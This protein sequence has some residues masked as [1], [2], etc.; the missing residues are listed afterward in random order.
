MTRLRAASLYLAPILYG[1]RVWGRALGIIR[2]PAKYEP[3]K[4]G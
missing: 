2:D 4:V 1:L 3:E